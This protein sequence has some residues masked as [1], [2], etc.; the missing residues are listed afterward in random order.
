MSNE[1]PQATDRLKVTALDTGQGIRLFRVGNRQIPYKTWTGGGTPELRG[2]LQRQMTRLMF[3][4]MM[5]DHRDHNPCS[6]WGVRRDIRKQFFWSSKLNAFRT[7]QRCNLL[8]PEEL[9]HD[10]AY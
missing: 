9:I 5:G 8:T 2:T 10:R 3:R 6:P 7:L 1:Q 4:E